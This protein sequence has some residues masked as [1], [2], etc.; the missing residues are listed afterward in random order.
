MTRE[1]RIR[2]IR[3][4]FRLSGGADAIGRDVDDEIRFHLET[5]TSA[6]M[7]EGLDATTARAQAQRE[8]GDARAAHDEL[9]LVARRRVGREQRAAWWDGID[10][11]LRY[12][13]RVLWQRRGFT[14]V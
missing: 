12:T 14:A 8:F 5:R 3:R 9:A 13:L 7:A 11:D 10:R 1:P 2:G 6:L 4:L